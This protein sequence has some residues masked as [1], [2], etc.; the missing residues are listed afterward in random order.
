MDNKINEPDLDK[1]IAAD[2]SMP[3]ATR[4]QAKQVAKGTVRSASD[5]KKNVVSE[6]LQPIVG[7]AITDIVVTALATVSDIIIGAVDMKLYGENRHS[8]ASSLIGRTNYNS[9]YRSTSSIVSG[10]SNSLPLA[11]TSL[12]SLYQNPTGGFRVKEVLV[13]DRGEAELVIDAL[14]EK[15]DIYG[16]VTVG[17]YYDV[18]GIPTTAIDFKYGW[19]N[20]SAADK[21]RTFDGYL[22]VMPTPK[23]I[24]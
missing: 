8:R 18:V 12:S 15:L 11:T 19:Y 9:L 21:R 10:L 13:R 24:D 2:I 7:R 4:P 14:C 5:G 23:P 3:P 16:V 1:K 6:I 20:L 22:I 17:E